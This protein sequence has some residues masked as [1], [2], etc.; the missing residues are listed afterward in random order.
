MLRVGLGYL[1]AIGLLVGLWAGLAPRSFYEDFPGLGRVW[2][3]VDGPFNEHLVRDVGW[4]NLALTV[5]TVWAAVTLGRT[6][7]VAVLVAWLVMSLPHL[8]YHLGH[9]D[10]LA[11][12]DR[13]GELASLALVPLVAAALLAVVVRTRPHA[14]P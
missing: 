12:S 7:V 2:V 6:L 10:G 14:V 4:L 11:T 1:A 3:A 9:L 8:A 5:A 13:V